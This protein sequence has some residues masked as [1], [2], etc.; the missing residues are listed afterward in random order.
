MNEND[1]MERLRVLEGD[2]KQVRVD[3]SEVRTDIAEIRSEQR[4]TSATMDKVLRMLE[5][6]SDARIASAAQSSDIAALK[7]EFSAMKA[8]VNSL[9]EDRA[10]R[11]AVESSR[12]KRV[13]LYIA[14]AGI[15]GPFLVDF[16]KG[17]G[18]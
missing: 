13:A 3:V 1:V 11:S 18:R 14:I 12:E 16:L 4:H 5:G 10:G 7:V 17:L 15:G 6:F 8:D 9:K 2:V